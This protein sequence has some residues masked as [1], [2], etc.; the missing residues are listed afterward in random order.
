MSVMT[1]KNKQ[2]LSPKQRCERLNELVHSLSLL[3]PTSSSLGRALYPL[4]WAQ[5]WL[6]RDGPFTLHQNLIKL[7]TRLVGSLVSQRTQCCLHQ[8][9]I[10]ASV[11]PISQ[12]AWWCT[13]QPDWLQIGAQGF[14]TLPPCLGIITHAAESTVLQW[15]RGHKDSDNAERLAR[16]FVSLSTIGVQ[17]LWDILILTQHTQWKWHTFPWRV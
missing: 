2:A 1:S 17:R 3:P 5:C 4:I 14:A 9:L 15:Q 16:L 11:W 8:N 13:R 6:W 10:R 7:Q 12:R